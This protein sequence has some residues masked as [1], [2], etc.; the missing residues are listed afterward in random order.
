MTVDH[1][2]VSERSYGCSFGCGN[3]YDYIFISV[4]GGET[5]F[6]CLPDFVRLASDI[7]ATV[8]TPDPD[9]VAQWLKAISPLDQAPHRGKGARTRGH[10]APAE[11]DDPELFDAFDAVIT[12][13][14]LGD[15]FR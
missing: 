13:D 15:E 8:T 14:E 4:A 12:S 10:N 7:V 3:P 6:L 1:H 2:A 9:Q 5:L 11:V